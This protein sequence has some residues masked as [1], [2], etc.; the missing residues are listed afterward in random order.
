[1]NG[2]AGYG[3]QYHGGSATRNNSSY[4]RRGAPY[5]VGQSF[6]YM[7]SNYHNEEAERYFA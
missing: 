3:H 5:E 7:P 4:Q 2:S 6:H 1:M